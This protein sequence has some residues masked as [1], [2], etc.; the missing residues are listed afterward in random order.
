MNQPWRARHDAPY[1]ALIGAVEES[2]DAETACH[3]YSMLA[4]AQTT[5]QRPIL[6]ACDV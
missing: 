6:Y 5:G 3:V 2:D 1:V 4:Y